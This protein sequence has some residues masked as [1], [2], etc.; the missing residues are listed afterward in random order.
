[1]RFDASS[2][3]IEPLGPDHDRTAF[4]CGNESLN[5]YIRSQA[6]QDIRRGI[7]R[8]F[9]ATTADWPE[10]ILAFFTLSAASVV[11]A[12]LPPELAKRL[13]RHPIPAALIGRLAVDRE[14]AGRGLGSILLADAVK[15]TAMASQTLAVTV[16]VVDPVDDAAR[17]FYSSFGFRNLQTSQN[18][19]FLVLASGIVPP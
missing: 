16:V 2:L 7:A 14:F 11:A 19:M 1:V 15:K 8:V 13:P 10:R 18:R 12:E 4:S 17:T 5:R 6:T 9:V 3:L